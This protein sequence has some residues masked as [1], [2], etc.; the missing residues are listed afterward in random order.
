MRTVNFTQKYSLLQ[1]NGL[2]SYP[3][4]DYDTYVDFIAGINSSNSGF[5]VYQPGFASPITTFQPTT[6]YLIVKTAGLNFSLSLPDVVVPDTIKLKRRYNIIT[7]PYSVP[8]SFDRYRDYIEAVLIPNPSGTGFLTSQPGFPSPFTTFVPGSTYLVVAYGNFD[9][10]NPD[11]SPTPT[12]TP[13]PTP[14]NTPTSTA[15]NTPTPTRTPTQTASQTPT[16]TPGST[17]TATPTTTQ[18]PT[19]SVTIGAT[20]STTPTQTQTPTRTP[21]QTSTPT[22][23]IT[24]TPTQTKTPTSTV[25]PTPSVTRPNTDRTVTAT[26][27][28]SITNTKTPTQTPTLTPSATQPPAAKGRIDFEGGASGDPH[29]QL[30]LKMGIDIITTNTS[31]ILNPCKTMKYAGYGYQVPGIITEEYGIAYSHKDIFKAQSYYYV[32]SGA[33]VESQWKNYLSG[34]SI[35]TDVAVT[36]ANDV[37]VYNY[38]NDNNTTDYTP[39][40]VVHDPINYFEELSGR[41]LKETN[42]YVEILCKSSMMG[43][44]YNYKMQLFYTLS[45]FKRFIDED[46]D[47]LNGSILRD[48][49]VKYYPMTAAVIN[50]DKTIWWRAQIPKLYPNEKMIYKI[51]CWRN[52]RN[53]I[54]YNPGKIGAQWDDNGPEASPQETLLFYVKNNDRWLA[55]T[56]TNVFGGVAGASVV[57]EVYIQGSH[58]PDNIKRVGTVNYTDT[59]LG[60]TFKGGYG[61]LN[62]Y[63]NKTLE[64]DEIGGG[65]ALVLMRTGANGGTGWGGGWGPDVRGYDVAGE[66]FGITRQD[67]I[68]AARDGYGSA[69]WNKVTFFFTSGN[70]RT[71]FSSLTTIAVD[72]PCNQRN[73][74]NF[75]WDPLEPLPPFLPD[76]AE[77]NGGS[78]RAAYKV[79][80]KINNSLQPYFLVEGPEISYINNLIMDTVSANGII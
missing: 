54:M 52:F 46:I 38:L 25:A 18:T 77:W 3:F 51:G 40:W 79:P 61:F 10:E 31:I 27:T 74:I 78:L 26:P 35:P 63:T 59:E 15:T 34:G 76:A 67:L 30:S 33:F 4:S 1:F 58:V 9:I 80:S 14:G 48:N 64:F 17:P 56:H 11:P 12:G 24:Q 5:S 55:I 13:P 19:P 6:G 49:S 68:A 45:A 53:D 57:D 43:D 39:A 60:I 62:F 42:D 70:T 50:E 23:T 16:G 8:M 37:S 44:Y 73:Y 22:P 7:F 29:L 2:F 21:V 72:G 41:M 65:L 71:I 28:P 47:T 69:S 66:A 75:T 32:S 36:Y 20:P